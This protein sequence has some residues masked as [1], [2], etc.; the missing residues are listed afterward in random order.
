MRY[1]PKVQIKM[2]SSRYSAL[3]AVVYGQ[4]DVMLD[5]ISGT[6]SSINFIKTAF[7]Y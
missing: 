3:S 6:S 5:M 4:V 7:N 1:L 2:Y